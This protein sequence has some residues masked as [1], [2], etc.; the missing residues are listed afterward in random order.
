MP[1]LVLDG[2][3]R[4]A[5]ETVQSLGR[6]G[7]ETDVAAE[8]LSC[9]V[10]RSRYPRRKLLQPQDTASS[11]FHDWLREQHSRRNYELIVPTTEASLLAFRFLG[12]TDALRKRA[13]LPDNRALDIA[14]DK[15]K[16]G[17]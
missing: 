17:S 13:A 15:Q 1:V 9:P 16:T 4:A 6:A 14:L 3:S 11:K 7:I 5:V 10:M 8:S 2:H 12:E